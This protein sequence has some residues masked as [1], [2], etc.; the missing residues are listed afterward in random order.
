[1]FVLVLVLTMALQMVRVMRGVVRVMRVVKV[2]MRV[3]HIC[4]LRNRKLQ[5]P[6]GWFLHLSC[7]NTYFKAK[8]TSVVTQFIVCTLI[9]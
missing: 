8:C 7:Q 4:H 5:V 6:I 2:M 3:T 1:M 9:I